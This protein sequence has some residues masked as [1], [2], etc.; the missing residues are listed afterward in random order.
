MSMTKQVHVTGLQEVAGLKL[1]CRKCG[2]AATLAWDRL[3]QLTECPFCRA[4]WP[5]RSLAYLADAARA[6]NGPDQ[7]AVGIEIVTEERAEG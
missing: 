5:T 4:D 7:Q 3:A 1:T 6:L 2:G